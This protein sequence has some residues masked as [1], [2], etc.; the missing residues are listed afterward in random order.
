MQISIT[1][2][3]EECLAGT[4]NR[5]V[6]GFSLNKKGSVTRDLLLASRTRFDD[7]LLIVAKTTVTSC[8]DKLSQS[9]LRKLATPQ[10]LIIQRVSETNR[11]CE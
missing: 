10:E 7:S 6:R 3:Q 1:D 4:C 9:A 11:D 8:S 5:I 2:N